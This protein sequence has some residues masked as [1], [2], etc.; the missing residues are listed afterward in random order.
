MKVSFKSAATLLT[1]WLVMTACGGENKETSTS[2]LD[3]VGGSIA[4]DELYNEHFQSIVSLQYRGQSFCGGT[5]VSANQVVTAAHCV[6]QFAN[7]ASALEVVVGTNDLRDVR[8]AERFNA[9]DIIIHSSYSS[10]STNYDIAL[11]TLNGNSSFKPVKINRDSA[12]PAVG[13]RT[14]T[15]GWGATSEGGYSSSSL[16]YTGVEVVSNQQCAQVYG[17]SIYSGSLCAYAQGTDSCQ[18]DSGGPLYAW[19]E[20]ENGLVLVGVVS[21][22][23]GCARSGTPGVYTRVSTFFG[24]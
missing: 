15:A 7:A 6:D 24:N 12:F 20:A 3:I 16:K 8:A 22:G 9:S 23:R 21:F 14:W 11:I 17:S 18:G 5:L 4:S 10:R 1:G 2:G 13:Q 19:D